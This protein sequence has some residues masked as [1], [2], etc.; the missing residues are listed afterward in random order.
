MPNAH[1]FDGRLAMLYWT[2]RS[3]PETTIGQMAA[4]IRTGAPNVNAV[5]V[6]TNNG[7]IWQGAYDSTKPNLAINSIADV[8][9]W[10]SALAARGLECHAWCVARGI[11]PAQEAEMIANICLQGGVKSMLLDLE[12]GPSYFVGDQSAAQALAVGIR[13]RVGPDFHVGLIFDARGNRPQQLWVQSIWFPEIDS[14]MPMVY[15]YHF[16]ISAEQALANCYAAI[17]NWDKPVYPMLEAYT[18]DGFSTP[19]P[20]SEATHAANVAINT[21]RAAGLSFYRYGIGLT[22]SDGGMNMSELAAGI[23]PIGLPVPPA[24]VE[25]GSPPVP[26]PTGGVV[27]GPPPVPGPMVP[28]LVIIDPNNER[29]GEF[30]VNYYG[31]PAQL[32]P[33]W[34]V[35]VDVNGRPYAYRA[36]SYNTQTLYVSYAPRLTGKGKYVIEAFIPHEHAYARDVHYVI[37]DYPDGVR[38]ETTAILDQSPHNDVWVPLQGDIINGQPGGPLVSE[39]DLDPAFP[40]AGRVN[41]ADVTFIDPQTSPTGKFE[42]TFGAIRWRPASMVITGFDAPVGTEAER[43]GALAVGNQFNGDPIWVGNWY[44]ANPFLSRYRLGSGYAIHTG[45]DLNLIGAAIADKDAPVFA[46]ADGLVTCARFL[47]TGWKNVV[48]V[49]HPVQGENRVV[50]ARYAHLGNLFVQE[51]WQVQR[52]QKIGT[53]GEYAP[54]NYHLHFDISPTTILK[55]TPNHWPGD[56]LPAVRQDYVDPLAFIKQRHVLR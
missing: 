29:T 40:D 48:V 13:Q 44:D 51:G 14:L 3:V 16:G 24:T 30:A 8:Q 56:N 7:T 18:P 2:P 15:H 45:A 41:V 19:Y 37:V 11:S 27:V 39:F 25:V 17:G 28:T 12:S 5:F 6:K 21:H 32:S 38:R 1:L 42:I 10:S 49:E 55:T 4:D 26:P 20:P 46:V 31:D 22:T 53:I 9:R 50:Y 23:A 33:G 34:S 36:A 52:G 54:N 35:D 43:A 47:S